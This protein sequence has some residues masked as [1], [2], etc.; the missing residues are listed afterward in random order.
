MGTLSSDYG[1]KLKQI[2]TAEGLTQPA[3]AKE[4]GLGLSTVKNYETGQKNAGLSI[5]DKVTNHPRFEKYTMWL[6]NGKTSEAA[7]QISPTLSP[8]GHDDTS[9]HQKGQKVG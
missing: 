1:E 5:V 4:L 9:D 8:N 6:M 2:R 7:G 3:F